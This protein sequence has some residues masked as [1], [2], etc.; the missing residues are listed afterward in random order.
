[1]GRDWE[2]YSG[3][4]GGNVVIKEIKKCGLTRTEAARLE[5]LLDRY[6]EGRTLPNDCKYLRD[7]VSELRLS[8][9]RRIFRLYFADLGDGPVLLALHFAAKKKQLDKP[10]VDL[11]VE[12]L[13]AWQS[14]S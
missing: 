1:M 4:G 13:R 7:G 9:D 2:Y 5:E 6:S 10:A 11:A 8:G 3:P 14:D 12:R